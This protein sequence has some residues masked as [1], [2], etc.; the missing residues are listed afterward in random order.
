VGFTTGV[1]GIRPGERRTVALVATLMFV[2]LAGITIGESATNALSRSPD[3][4]TFR[5]FDAFPTAPRI[6]VC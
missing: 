5:T 2:T 1:L 3:G 4:R 6:R